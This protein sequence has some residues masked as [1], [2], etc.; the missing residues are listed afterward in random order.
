MIGTTLA[1][2][3]AWI[4]IER[5]WNLESDRPEMWIP[6]SEM[7]SIWPWVRCFSNLCVCTL[8]VR[9]SFHDTKRLNDLP[10][11]TQMVKSQHVKHKLQFST[12]D[13]LVNKCLL[14]LE[15]AEPGFKSLRF[16]C[17]MSCHLLYYHIHKGWLHR[18]KEHFAI[19]AFF[20]GT[21]VANDNVK[22][23]PGK[24]IHID[25]HPLFRR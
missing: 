9:I 20:L 19:Y 11:F 15:V 25:H 2:R 22:I 18:N 3:G 14:V 23:D 5:K 7:M 10:K 24:I 13:E 1:R 21:T 8:G 6:V 4:I 12:H 16:M 17:F